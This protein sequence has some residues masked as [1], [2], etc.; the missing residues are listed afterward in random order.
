MLLIITE[1]LEMLQQMDP[2]YFSDQVD[3]TE[4]NST[5]SFFYFTN[6]IMAAIYKLIFVSTMP[7][8]QED[9]KLLLQNLVE[10]VGDW[11]CYQDFT[12]LRVYGFEGEPYKLPKFLT[13]RIFVLEFL[14]QR[15][16]AENDIFVQ[17]KKAS[18]LKFKWTVEPFVI[19][20]FPVLYKIEII[21]KIMGF[22]TDKVVKYDPKGIMD[23]R[24]EDAGIDHYNVDLDELLA[25]L[26]N[27]DFLEPIIGIEFTDNTSETQG[28]YNTI[29]VQGTEIPTL[30]KGE[31]SLKRQSA[32]T[33]DMEVDIPSKRA[34]I[35]SNH[36]HI[37]S[38]D[39]D[40]DQ[41]SINQETIVIITEEKEDQS[42]V[43]SKTNELASQMLTEQPTPGPAMLVQSF[44]ID[45]A[46][47]SQY[48]SRDDLV[49]DFLEERNKYVDENYKLLQQAKKKAPTGSTTLLIVRE[50]D[51]NTLR[52]ATND[53][54]H[55][56]Q[57]K[58]QMDKIG[59]PDKINFHKQATEVLYSDLLKSYLNKTKLEGKMAKLEE[60]IKREKG[61]SARW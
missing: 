46:K 26:A 27:S 31:K 52:I 30:H 48:H 21:L 29:V 7:R 6:R 4:R 1:N 45:E 19:D 33:A 57:V 37:I 24:K 3:L 49:K 43:P 8:I 22:L 12:I 38:L 42:Q 54:H 35:S 56:S 10:P 51:S 60:Q 13:R 2:T 40:N 18:G 25:A 36:V 47:S 44:K 16:T 11:F 41:G 59:I 5:M 17:H 53:P 14:R 50:Q 15:L 34:K 20:F 23:Q 58:I 32:D 39:E 9:F 55:V 61:R 28:M